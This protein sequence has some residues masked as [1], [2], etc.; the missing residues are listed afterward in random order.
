MTA[1]LDLL[2]GQLITA[3]GDVSE[4][5]VEVRERLTLLEAKI[6]APIDGRIPTFGAID[7]ASTVGALS[8]RS[9]Q[10]PDTLSSGKLKVT[11]LL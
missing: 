6:P 9:D 11:G 1:R 4:R 5:L 8:V 3:I 7:A 10:L 2:L